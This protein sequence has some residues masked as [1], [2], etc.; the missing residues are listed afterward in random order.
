MKSVPSVNL[1]HDQKALHRLLED[2]KVDG[3]EIDFRV[4]MLPSE[5]ITRIDKEH[6]ADKFDKCDSAVFNKLIGIGRDLVETVM[7]HTS[8]H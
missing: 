8:P 2:A 5:L 7:K 3:V 1:Y 6:P 4:F